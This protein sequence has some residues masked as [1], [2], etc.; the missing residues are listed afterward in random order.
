VLTSRASVGSPAITVAVALTLKRA[1][2]RAAIIRRRM[3]FE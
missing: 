2:T 3:W 1:G